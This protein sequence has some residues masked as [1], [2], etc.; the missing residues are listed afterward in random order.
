V[1]TFVLVHGAW[2]GAW[3]WDRVLP[4]L[5]AR[6]HRAVAVELPS[7]DPDAGTQAY[8]RA[9][10][11]HVVDPR[12]TVLVAHSMAGLVAP[13]YAERRPVRELVLLASLLPLPGASWRDQS[14]T[15]RPMTE[16][17]YDE[18]LPHQLKDDRG[19]SF[20]T[21]DLAANLFYHDCGPADAAGAAA[22]LRPQAATVLTEPTPWTGDVPCPVRY[23]VCDADRAVSGRWG[24]E[25][26][27]AR[28]GAHVDHLPTSHS[29]FWSR[30]A[31]LAALLTAG[32]PEGEPTPRAEEANR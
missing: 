27:T 31:D 32:H 3:C 24:Q 7:D 10:D 6:G 1:S 8:L 14:S 21:P 9:I 26:A 2:H 23:I 22:R 19:R 16:D 17:F 15:S 4:E 18:F 25:T 20:W 28:L 11:G 5:R 13:V 12:T 30:P 29:P